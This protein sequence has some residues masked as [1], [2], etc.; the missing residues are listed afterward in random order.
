MSKQRKFALLGWSLRAIEAIAKMG[1]D[2]VV[3]APKWAEDYAKQNEIPYVGWD[4]ERLNDRSVELYEALDEAGVSLAIPLFEE[5]VEWA[6]ALNSRFLE[7]PRLFPQAMLFRDKALMKRRAQMAGIRVGVFEEAHDRDDVR[8]FLLRVNEA[9]LKLQGDPNDPIHMKPF[10][11]A[12]TYGHRVIED[13]EQISAIGDDEFPA[14]LE[15]HLSGKE[16][17][18]EVF[19]HDR[20]IQFLNISE[21]VHLGYSVFIPA[22]PVLEDWRPRIREEIEKLIEAFDIDHGL[23]HPEYFLTADGTLHFG[24]VAYRVPGGNAFELMERAYGFSA[25]QGQVLCMD[26]DTTQEELDKFFPTEVK[27]A[28]GYAGCFLVYPKVRVI[29]DLKVPSEVEND[30]YYEYNDLFVPADAKV[31]E[32]VAFGNHY[33]SVYFFGKDPERLRGLLLEQEDYDY[34]I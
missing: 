2:Y 34:Y 22:S 29:K 31:A 12:G 30:P 8:R 20:K 21:Y 24:E 7:R 14:L 33:G 13:V 10:D 9:L 15:S 16:F 1:R 4:F 28:K 5:T 26:P 6:G 23:I 19:I 25:Y 32:R 18:C 27:D 3:V 11:K 17:A